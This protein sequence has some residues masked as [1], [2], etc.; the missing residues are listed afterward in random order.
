MYA[1]WANSKGKETYLYFYE[2]QLQAHH[3][4]HV[5][6]YIEIE[7]VGHPIPNPDCT[8]SSTGQIV[9]AAARDSPPQ[10]ATPN[11]VALQPVIHGNDSGTGQ[12]RPVIHGNDSG[13]G[14]VPPSHRR[15]SSRDEACV[16]I[17]VCL[18]V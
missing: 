15:R 17:C 4:Q 12:V 16:C 2:G 18:R 7:F 11:A 3:P 6:T 13:T 8:H 14:H 9:L 1:T 5:Y 10:T